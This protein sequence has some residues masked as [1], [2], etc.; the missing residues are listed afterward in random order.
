MDPHP[1]KETIGRDT[2][3]VHAS[4]VVVQGQGVLIIGPSGSGKSSLA[5]QMM[6]LGAQLVGDDRIDLR[7]QDG[8]AI[9][10]AMP[11]IRDLIEARGIGLLRAQCA[12][13]VPLA[14]VVDL[15]QAEPDRLPEPEHIGVLRQTVPLLRVAG[16]PNLAAA[17]I[18]LVKMGR[19]DPE[20]PNI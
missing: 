1:L 17:L 12:G 5:L 16:T 19:V 9:A 11:N 8:Q 3:C 7:M 2:A 6:A 13:P 4:C 14:Y 10:D 18:Q 15:G 20:W